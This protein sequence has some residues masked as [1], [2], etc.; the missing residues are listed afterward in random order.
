[1]SGA[2]GVHVG[3]LDLGPRDARTVVG[4]AALVGLSTHDDRQLS[5]GAREAVSYLAMGP[6]FSTQTKG[7]AI[8]PTVGLDGVRRAAD[9]L[10]GRIPLVAIGGITIER[11]P[12]V[13]AAGATSVAVISDLLT[14][15]IEDRAR[16][17]LAAVA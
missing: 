17:F 13:L 4:D 3:Q 1:M 14:G 9:V 6:V 15:S 11:A 5:V 2:D 12:E 10:Q 16:T 7:P 8:D